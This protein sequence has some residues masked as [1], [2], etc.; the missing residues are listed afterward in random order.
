MSVALPLCTT[1]WLVHHDPGVRQGKAHVLVAGGQQ[2]RAHGRGLAEAKRRYGRLDELHRVINR[3]SG[4]NHATGRIDVQ[5]YFLLRV[6]GLEKQ[7]LRAHKRRHAIFNRA[8]DGN[9]A[10]LE[11]AR[12][13]VVGAFATIG[14]FNNH[15][16]KVHRGFDWIS[17]H[18]SPARRAVCRVVARESSKFASVS[19]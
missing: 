19:K 18:W 8:G 10:L 3:H 1:G 14:L 7:K 11:K 5:V 12:K 13:D 6:F 2:E 15:R 9:D 4:R 17:H 16:H